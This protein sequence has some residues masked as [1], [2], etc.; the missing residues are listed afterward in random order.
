MFVNGVIVHSQAYHR[1]KKRN[2]S[3]VHIKTDN[4]ISVKTFMV[5]DV[6]ND[7]TCYAICRFFEEGN[8]SFSASVQNPLHFHPVKKV[9]FHLYPG[10]ENMPQQLNTNVRTCLWNSTVAIIL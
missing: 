3:V 4:T 2:S 7:S 5:T 8:L 10:E 6:G 9:L 1:S